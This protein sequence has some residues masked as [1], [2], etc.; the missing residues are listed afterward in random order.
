MQRPERMVM[1]IIGMFFGWFILEM[2]LVVLAIATIATT[3][4]RIY[5]VAKKLSDENLEAPDSE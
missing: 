3:F 5:T 4:Q 1:I 2:V